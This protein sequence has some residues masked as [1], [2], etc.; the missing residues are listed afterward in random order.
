MKDRVSALEKLHDEDLAAKQH[1]RRIKNLSLLVSLGSLLVAC[2]SVS[3]SYFN[4][5]TAGQQARLTDGAACV[6]TSCSM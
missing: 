1:E 4:Y 6:A 5:A 3:I 2:G